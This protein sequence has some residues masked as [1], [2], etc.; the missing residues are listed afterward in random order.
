MA[1]IN[2]SLCTLFSSGVTI[3]GLK[4]I[5]AYT[6]EEAKAPQQLIKTPHRA[7]FLHY[8]ALLLSLVFSN[9]GFT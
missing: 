5:L 1:Y 7:Y 6:L 2:Y 3:I 9:L 4:E 8:I